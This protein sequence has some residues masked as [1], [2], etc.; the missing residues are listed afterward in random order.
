MFG[1]YI[2]TRHYIAQAF[3]KYF[4]NKL[5]ENINEWMKERILDWKK[6]GMSVEFGTSL[7]K[8]YIFLQ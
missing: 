8:I 7:F 6:E 2:F 1:V 3:N 5:T 4:S